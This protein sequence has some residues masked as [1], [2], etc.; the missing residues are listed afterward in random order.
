MLPSAL[1]IFAWLFFA[2]PGEAQEFEVP[3]QATVL[4]T[5]D[6]MERRYRT[7]I[8]RPICLTRRR[9][10]DLSDWSGPGLPSASPQAVSELR[11]FLETGST[12]RTAS[13]CRWNHGL[14]DLEIIQRR[15]APLT[16]ESI[17]V[18]D[19][20]PVDPYG[21]RSVFLAVSSP[22]ASSDGRIRVG[23]E[24]QLHIASKFYLL[25]FFRQ[26]GDAWVQDGEC[27][28]RFETA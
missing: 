1:V 6:A 7:E 28:A 8:Q 19:V 18:S 21:A 12:Y 25:C 5:L 9:T 14:G 23:A 11:E 15:R 3:Q 26:I 20:W 13:F 4:A 17:L 10:A 27:Q 16:A 22:V 24:A 2:A